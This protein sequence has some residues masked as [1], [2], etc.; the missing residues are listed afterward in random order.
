MAVSERAW[1]TMRNHPTPRRRTYLSLLDWK[2]LWMDNRRFPFTVFVGQIRGVN[3]AL[4]MV[5]EEGL[6]NRFERHAKAARLCRAGARALG[7]GLWPASDDIMSTCVTAIKV[8]EGIDANQLIAIM[9]DTYGVSI[10]GSL[11]ELAGK[12]IRIG[13]MAHMAQ[14][15]FVVMALAALE[16][17]L[18]DLG[19]D[20]RL[21]EG[22]GA[23]LAAM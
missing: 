16:R 10:T 14:P 9:R 4:T 19:Y 12:V 8:P 23:A 13:H 11:K 1:E 18:Y 22:V 2:E 5:L 3:E 7:L 17:G 6:Q 21:G 20:V 15:M